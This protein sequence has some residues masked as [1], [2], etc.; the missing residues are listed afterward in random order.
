MPFFAIRSG[1][2]LASFAAPVGEIVL[3]LDD[4]FGFTPAIH[5]V[6]VHAYGGL[7]IV[8]THGGLYI[9]VNCNLSKLRH[10]A[11]RARTPRT[12]RSLQG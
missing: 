11:Y 5:L 2:S 9:T 6:I 12:G 8:H 7:I 4:W 10:I 3:R 1:I